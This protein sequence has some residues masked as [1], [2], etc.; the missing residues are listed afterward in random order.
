V[1][2]VTNEVESASASYYN[3]NDIM[4]ICFV[5]RSRAYAIIKQLNDE[6]RGKGYL[7]PRAGITPKS[8]ADKKL[9]CGAAK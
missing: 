9:Y 5:G 8:Y 1:L 7:I 2:Q 6:L 4:R 3:V